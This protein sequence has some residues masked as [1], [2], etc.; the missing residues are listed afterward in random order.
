MNQ[1]QTAASGTLAPRGASSQ[2]L[3]EATIKASVGGFA[4]GVPTLDDNA[5]QLRDTS[6][7]AFLAWFGIVFVVAFGIVW[8]YVATAPMA[9]LSRDYP[10]WV[11]KRTLM[12][13][14]RLGSVLV[15]GDSRAMA[16]TVPNVMPVSVT[17]LAQS[18][19]SPIETYFAVRR[20]LRCPTPP[21]LVVIAHS[22]TKFGGDSDYWTSF[23]R[24]GFLDYADMRQVDR[25]AADL[26]DKEILDLPSMGHL[27]PALRDFLFAVRFPPLYFGSLVNGFIAVR[28][29]HNHDALRESLLSSG[30]AVF[31]NHSGSSGITSEGRDPIYETSPLENLYFSRTLALLADRGVPV[32]LF[33]IP[34]NRSTYMRM[35]PEYSARFDDYLQAEARHFPNIH[36]A[37]PVI[38][39]WPDRFFGDAWHFNTQGATAYS[40][41]LGVWLR[42]ELTDG[43]IKNLPN[44]CADSEPGMGPSE[45]TVTLR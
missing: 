13:E 4:R 25:D 2:Q 45:P 24:N 33:A 15:F 10:L 43:T 3:K 32:L 27:Q 20:A 31:G 18:G 21:R 7:A 44:A 40:R 19:A 12:D 38:S 6:S 36:V 1:S 14:C 39:C 26:H 28:W 34:I 42:D 29:K 30:H 35:P 8:V 16:A 41:E 9:F 5:D 22:A 37:S 23:A 17:N 11:A